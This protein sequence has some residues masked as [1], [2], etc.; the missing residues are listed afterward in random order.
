MAD[1][2]TDRL[3]RLDQ[4]V[5]FLIAIDALKGVLRQSPIA[6]GSRTPQSIRG[7]WP[8]RQLCCPNMPTSQSIPP[9]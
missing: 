6:D 1:G 8:W 3:E 5:G 4:Q 2:L 7:S 9:G